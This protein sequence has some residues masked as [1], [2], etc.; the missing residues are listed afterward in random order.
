M[1]ILL[2]TRRGDA[3]TATALARVLEGHPDVRV[4]QERRTRPLAGPSVADRRRVPAMREHERR[5]WGPTSG[6][7]RARSFF[8]FEG[9]LT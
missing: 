6:N 7:R 8:S 2:I 5:A 3:N 1:P 4:I 9:V